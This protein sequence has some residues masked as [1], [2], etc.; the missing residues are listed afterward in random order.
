MLAWCLNLVGDAMQRKR[1]DKMREKK[2]FR[3]I[4]CYCLH[5]K[6]KRYIE[7]MQECFDRFHHVIRMRERMIV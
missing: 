1:G 6:K 3:R 5:C 2:R 4:E 7:E